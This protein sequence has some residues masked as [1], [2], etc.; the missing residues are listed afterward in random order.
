MTNVVDLTE[1]DIA[2]GMDGSL[3]ALIDRLTHIRDSAE[4]KRIKNIR[5]FT[6]YLDEG[7]HWKLFIVGDE[8]PPYV[9]KLP[10]EQ[11]ERFFKMGVAAAEAGLVATSPVSCAPRNDLFNEAWYA[12]YKSVKV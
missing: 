12:G 2:D 11:Y 9:A 5:V 7:K 10:P 8:P 4:R 3:T 6:D 1:I